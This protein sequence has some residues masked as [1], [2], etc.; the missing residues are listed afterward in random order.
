MSALTALLPAADRIARVAVVVPAR[1]EE[2]LIS[3]CLDGLLTAGRELSGRRPEI[4]VALVE[5]IRRRTDRWIATD[6]TRVSSSGRLTGRCEGGFADYLA[7]LAADVT[8]GAPP[9]TAP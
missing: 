8:G 5:A 4:D 9:V 1:N 6:R 2:E 3:S 7:G